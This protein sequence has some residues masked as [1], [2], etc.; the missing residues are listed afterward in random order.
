MT[1]ELSHHKA[2]QGSSDIACFGSSAADAEQDWGKSVSSSIRTGD[3]PSGEQVLQLL[4]M[5][6]A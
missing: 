5:H 1:L 6:V 3:L 4:L 2:R